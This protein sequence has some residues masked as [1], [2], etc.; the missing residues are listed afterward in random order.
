[1]V[2]QNEGRTI[3]SASQNGRA[4][5]ESCLLDWPAQVMA[6]GRSGEKAVTSRQLGGVYVNP[7]DLG[8]RRCW[9]TTSIYV[10]S[11]RIPRK[12]VARDTVA[13]LLI[14]TTGEISSELYRG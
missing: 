10:A 3:L 8:L 12:M 11:H 5:I 7:M 6:A 2:D 4:A 9:L 13:S 1:M 14:L